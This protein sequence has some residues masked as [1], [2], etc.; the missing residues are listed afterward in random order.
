MPVHSSRLL[1]ERGK[2]SRNCVTRP[3]QRGGSYAYAG[4]SS[5]LLNE[6]GKIRRNCVTAAVQEYKGARS[7]S[8]S[9]GR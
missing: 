7:A 9:L 2:I 3:L 1:N 4:A 5:R 8:R 6:R